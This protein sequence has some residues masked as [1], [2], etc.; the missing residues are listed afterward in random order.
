MFLM[1]RYGIVEY[2]F[3]S[4]MSRVV[5]GNEILFLLNKFQRICLVF[6]CFVIIIIAYQVTKL[7]LKFKLSQKSNR[8]FNHM[9]LR[10]EKHF[11]AKE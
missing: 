1:T 10:V 3:F 11:L 7:T 4:D 6:A 9:N 2:V 5:H 8:F